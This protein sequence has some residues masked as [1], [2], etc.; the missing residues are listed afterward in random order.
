MLNYKKVV[1]SGVHSYQEKALIFLARRSYNENNYNKS[2]LYYTKLLDLA[3]SNSLKRE[4][5]IRLMLGNEHTDILVALKYAKQV[6]DFDKVDDWLLSKA[7]IIIA[8][9][10]FDA[11][12][13]A[14]SKSTFERVSN[15][16]L[17]D[18]GAEAKYYLAYLTYLDEELSL[19]EQL[20]FA[21]ADNYNNDHFIAKAYIL[22][23][24]I[25]LAQ[26][27]LFQAQA[28]LESVI[29]NHDG[30]DLVNVARKKWEFILET[31]KEIAVD[32]IE[33]QSFIE[34]SEE[35]FEYEVIEIDEDYTVPIPEV[36]NLD[37]D[38]LEIINQNILIDEFE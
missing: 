25:Y 24:D 1:E 5:A 30:E 18:E 13:Y 4:V 37:V 33:E 34:I 21:L 16:S 3:S 31:K 12:N 10:E 8:R 17:Y 23:S 11:G 28:T 26:D 20:I 32:E 14:K 35:D 22:L 9:C 2:N 27:N 15:L 7:Y 36:I 19:A 6:V 29:E 38:S